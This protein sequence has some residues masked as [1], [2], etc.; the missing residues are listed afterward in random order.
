MMVALE[1]LAGRMEAAVVIGREVSGKL[2]MSVGREA[3]ASWYS[4]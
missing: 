1:V 2:V 3:G 4:C